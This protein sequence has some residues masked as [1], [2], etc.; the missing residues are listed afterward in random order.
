MG[1]EQPNRSATATP[2]YSQNINFENIFYS[3]TPLAS[4]TYH[5]TELY[6]SLLLSFAFSSI[7]S[8]PLHGRRPAHATTRRRTE[9]DLT[10]VVGFFD[11]PGA[12]SDSIAA[13]SRDPPDD[14]RRQKRAAENPLALHR[15]ALKQDRLLVYCRRFNQ[16]DRQPGGMGWPSPTWT[17][18]HDKPMGGQ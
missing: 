14:A 9:A 6:I 4:S 16:N 3:R 2:L 5:F 1:G 8:S 15:G 10:N 7:P 12:L 11:N 13:S 17:F 18:R